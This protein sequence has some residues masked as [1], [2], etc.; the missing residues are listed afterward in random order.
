MYMYIQSFNVES[1]RTFLF[2]PLLFSIFTAGG[3]PS[4]A[5]A[6]HVTM[7]QKNEILG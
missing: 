1:L 6:E 7:I 2:I 4:G 5:W 3:T